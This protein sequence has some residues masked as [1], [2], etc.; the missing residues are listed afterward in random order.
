[1]TQ[2]TT[3]LSL[4]LVLIYSLIGLSLSIIYFH[5]I[6]TSAQRQNNQIDD[7]G[8][9]A[10]KSKTVTMKVTL[11]LATQMCRVAGN[12][13]TAELKEHLFGDTQ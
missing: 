3:I 6:A 12:E 10:S 1:M 2:A 13:L 4:L 8:R 11:I 9:Q 5:F 7:C